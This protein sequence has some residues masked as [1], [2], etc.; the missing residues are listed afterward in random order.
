M[1]FSEQLIDTRV[2]ITPCQLAECL[3][4]Y[5]THAKCSHHADL[6]F[7]LKTHKP[8]SPIPT[9]Q[10]Q[11]SFQS[12]CHRLIGLVSPGP[13]WASHTCFA[14]S[15]EYL[16][17]CSLCLRSFALETICPEKPKIF[18][19][20]PLQKNSYRPLDLAQRTRNQD[21]KQPLLPATRLAAPTLEVSGPTSF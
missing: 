1:E 7:L 14:N 4:P 15:H 17:M 21:S 11:P 6:G 18:T 20:W 19:I 8:I 13:N 16:C 12:S 9:S 3:S 10:P 5:S 2:P